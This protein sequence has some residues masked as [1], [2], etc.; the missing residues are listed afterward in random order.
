MQV[1]SEKRQAEAHRKY[2]LK[3]KNNTSLI[4]F[5]CLFVFSYESCPEE[6]SLLEE[7]PATAEGQGSRG[8]LL[9]KWWQ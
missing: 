7:S 3:K 2:F 1:H 6:T 4:G 5:F 9:V 8:L